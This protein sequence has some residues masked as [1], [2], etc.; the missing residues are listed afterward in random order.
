MKIA[1]WNVNSI[2]ARMPILLEWLEENQPDLA[3]LQELKVEDAK[4]PFEEVEKAGWRCEIHGQ[5]TYNGVAFI[6]REPVAEVRRGLPGE[7]IDARVITADLGG[8]TFI[9]TYVPNGTAVGGDKWAYKM[10]WLERFDAWC[11]AELDPAKPMIWLGDINIAPSPDDVYEPEDKLGGVGH[12]PEE[13]SRLDQIK[14]W[15][16]ADSFREHVQGPG[17]YTFF[18]YRMRGTVERN[19]GWRIDHI[20]TSPGAAGA[21][22]KIWI[23][24]EPRKR[25]RPSD[26]HPVLALLRTP[27]H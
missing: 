11:R 7:N 12:H 2:R 23:D 8:F 19:L 13:F 26:H 4:F 6:T 17:H 16:W 9:N 22:E 21:V 14:A 20:Y 24:P 25:E 18:D 27:G 3:A 15:G 1:T 5:K 10:A